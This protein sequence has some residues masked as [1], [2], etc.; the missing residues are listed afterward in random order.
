[1]RRNVLVVVCGL[2][3]LVLMTWLGSVVV[4]IIPRPATAQMQ[5]AQAGPYQITVQVNPN[6]PSITQPTALSIRISL[7]STQ[8]LVTNAHV[9]LQSV[10]ET[11]DMGTDHANASMQSDGSYLAHVQFTTSGAWQ[12]QVFVAVPGQQ[13]VSAAFEITAR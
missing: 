12:V 2:A 4:D 8:Q 10:M 9:S 3:F 11:M 5:T 6:P 7:R 1:M 13:T